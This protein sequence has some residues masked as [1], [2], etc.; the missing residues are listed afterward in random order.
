[1]GYF[2]CSGGAANSAIGNTRKLF[3]RFLT[4]AWCLTCF[5]LITAF[6]S[7]LVSF[8]TAPEPYKP[9]INSVNDLPIKRDVQVTVRKGFFADIIFR[10]SK[11]NY[12]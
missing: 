12:I 11:S 10:V 2:I 4:G 1:M 9:I 7:V 8:L 6:S 3:I 5:V